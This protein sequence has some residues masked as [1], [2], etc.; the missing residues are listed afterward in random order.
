MTRHPKRTCYIAKMEPDTF[1]ARALRRQTTWGGTLN[2]THRAIQA[3]ETTVE[4]RISIMKELAEMAWALKGLPLPTYTRAEM[5]GRV[6]RLGHI[7]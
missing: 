2:L 3:D 1:E 4:A 7:P 5:P 6:I